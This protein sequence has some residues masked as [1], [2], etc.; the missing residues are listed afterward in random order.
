MGRRRSSSRR[1]DGAASAGDDDGAA[2]SDDE[3][4]AWDREEFSGLP[5]RV[6]LPVGYDPGLRYPLV[7]SLHGSGE[8][9]DDNVTQ[10]KNGLA[11]FEAP[12][13]R[14]FS[15]I[16]VAPQ[17]PRGQ[18][19]GGAWYGGPSALQSTVVDVVTGL[20]GRGSVDEDRVY[21][22]GF[23]MGAIGL[24]DIVVRYPGVFAAAVVIAGDVD[25]AAA[26]SLGSFPVWAVHGG[27]DP[28][29]K[30][31]HTR[32]LFA[33]QALPAFHYTEVDGVGHDVWRQA[34]FSQPRLWE[35][36]FAQRRPARR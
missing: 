21:G 13:L 15:P 33:S 19:F 27:A 23:S 22:V 26:S 14:S 10:L 30:P 18:T 2:V 4:G 3:F 7:V 11:A 24:W 28:L 25:V 16:V 32:A 35:W 29:V 17:A 20:A 5:C 9:G 34:F 31:A 8:R 6:L 12:A 1:R 36:L